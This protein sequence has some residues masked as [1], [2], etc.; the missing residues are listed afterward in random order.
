MKFKAT[1][2]RSDINF[3]SDNVQVGDDLKML[4]K[5]KYS[6]RPPWVLYK[7]QWQQQL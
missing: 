1:G 2:H 7:K 6:P 3:Q 4:V 5:M